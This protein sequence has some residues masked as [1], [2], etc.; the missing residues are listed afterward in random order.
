M[1]PIKN[2]VDHR[3]HLENTVI[4][5]NNKRASRAQVFAFIISLIVIL[6]GLGLIFLGMNVGG[7]ALVLGSL[8]TL[9]A[10]FF[11]GKAKNKK[12]LQQ[13]SEKIPD[14]SE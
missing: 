7:L 14:F 8:A 3:I 13:K 1:K 6:G 5:E 12:E 9:V 11:G 10:V 2:R 4:S